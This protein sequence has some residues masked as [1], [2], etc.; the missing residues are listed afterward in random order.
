[1]SKAAD[2]QS[3]R[4]TSD[5]A[6]GRWLAAYARHDWEDA[7]AGL[8]AAD[9]LT[10]LSGDDLEALAWSAAMTGRDDEFLAAIER[11]HNQAQSAGD[12]AR[13]ARTAFWMA[14]RLMRLREFARA[15]GWQSRLHGILADQ[16]ESLEHGYAQVLL[17]HRALEAGNIEE[18]RAAAA[19]GMRIGL[20]FGE[21]DLTEFCRNLE[22]RTL[23]RL[24]K[25]NEGLAMLDEAMLAASAGRLSPM[26]TGIVFCS[27]IAGCQM[28]YSIERSREWTAQLGEWCDAQ[29]QLGIYSGECMVHRAEIMAFSGEWPAAE[30]EVARAQSRLDPRVDP[31]ALAAAHY[32]EGEI[33]RL[34][35]ETVAAEAAYRAAS[36]V[37]TEPQPGL[38]LLR[39]A[40]G[41]ATAAAASIRQVLAAQRDPL[42]R[43]RYLPAAVEILL[44]V[45]AVE[46]AAEVA[47]ELGRTAAQYDSELLRAMAAHAAGMMALKRGRAAEAMVPLRDALQQWLRAG[48]PYLAARI[49]VLIAQACR[50]LGDEEGAGLEITAATRVF[51]ALGAV[52]DLSQ[53][54]KPPTQPA[55]ARPHGLTAREVEVLTLVASGQTNKGIG[56]VLGLSEKTID[57]HVSN[58]LTKLDV[59]TRSA[60]TAAAFQLG[61]IDTSP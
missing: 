33:H 35:G 55:A 32:Q 56:R 6:L 18:A 47:N 60:A 51:E 23:I 57:R 46:E 28:V 25:V 12:F 15:G 30:A 16:P 4:Q 22:G 44:S 26:L 20:R 27:L 42:R 17:F 52:P 24:G 7:F 5:S 8:S 13:M 21:P 39:L 38:A 3:V 59:P 14:L 1:M 54:G 19:E 31:E 37:G 2:R 40:N 48:S 58:I 49:R 50:L 29:P 11:L 10:P 43:V 45:E 34:R 53:I 61:L 36:A 9:R 41:N